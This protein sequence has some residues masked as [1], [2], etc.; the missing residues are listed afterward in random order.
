M[1]PDA[2][3]LRAH[4]LLI[5]KN[6][7]TDNSITEITAA[8]DRGRQRDTFFVFMASLLFS[9]GGLCMKL[10][11]WSPL[12]INGARN[13]IGAVVFGIFLAVS[14]HKLRLNGPVL[15]GSLC[16]IGVTSLFTVANKLTTA[17]NSIV[18]QYTAP[19]FVI[20]FMAVLFRQK[21]KK[22]DVLTCAAVLFGVCLFFIDGLQTGN[23]LG[24]IAALVSGVFYAGVFMM[25]T[26]SRADPLSSCFFGQL[27]AGLIFSPFYLRETDFSFPVV[28]AVLVL[29]AFQVGLAYIFFS[30]GLRRTPAVTASLISGLEP[31]LNPLWVA[32]FYGERITLLALCGAVIVVGSIVIY[33][34]YS[35]RRS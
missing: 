21:P 35:A 27:A 5:M 34:V 20:L 28:A 26:S 22:P 18:L 15:L 29:G 11:P 8:P 30:L 9:I 31:V 32:L 7:S 10:I 6:T 2:K 25:N 1:R 14:R 13:L 24:N 4:S 16:T 17:A 33:N 23:Q 3:P 12:A 19:V